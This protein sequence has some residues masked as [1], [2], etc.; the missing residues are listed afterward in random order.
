MTAQIIDA[1]TYDEAMELAYFGASVIHPQTLGPA[2]ANDIPIIIRN[3]F[4]PQKSGSRISLNNDSVRSIKGVAAIDDM[5]LINLEGAG[6]IGVP[7]TADRLFAALKDADVSVTLI[8]QASSEHSICIAV[9][10]ALAQR[11]QA[12]ISDAFAAE[13]EGGQIQSVEVT[14]ALSI[15]A[16]VGDNMAGHPGI[17][18]RLFG[19]LGRGGQ[20]LL[21]S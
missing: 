13:L 11:A 12:V 20:S 8:S 4:S 16:V 14:E 7:G 5:A 19:T 15:I 3:T 18:A 6:M 21:R 9:P 10:E 2:V 1:L 17:A